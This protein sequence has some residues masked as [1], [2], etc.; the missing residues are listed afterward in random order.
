VIKTLFAA[1]H[2]DVAPSAFLSDAAEKIKRMELGRM[3]MALS[4]ARFDALTMTFASA[5]MPPVLVHRASNGE[6]DEIALAATPL[7][8]LGTDYQQKDV[9]LAKGDTVLFLSDGFPELIDDDGH[10]LGYTAAL[11]LFAIAARESTAQRVIASLANEVDRWRGDS[12]PNDD[13]TFVVVRLT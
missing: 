4:L 1:Y 2:G 12:A 6:V 5:G 3:A 10:Q 7:G 11:D 9:Q 8:T 13:V